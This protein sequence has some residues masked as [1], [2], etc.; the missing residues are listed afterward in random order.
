MMWRIS[1]RNSIIKWQSYRVSASRLGESNFRYTQ[2]FFVNVPL[3]GAA[4]ILTFR[5]IEADQAK[6]R[7]RVFDLP[8]A[9]SVTGAVTLL[10]FALV[11]GPNF[12]WDSP[13]ILGA[14]VAGLL[15]LGVFAAI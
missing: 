5:L 2:V 13:G 4:L 3:A 1:R 10:V 12:G 8:G 11:L 14:A 9:L 15:L 6:D 7:D